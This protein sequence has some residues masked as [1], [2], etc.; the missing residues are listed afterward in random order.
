M[1]NPM[2]RSLERLAVED[3]DRRLKEWCQNDPMS[4]VRINNVY[5]WPWH[6]CRMVDTKKGDKPTM[7]IRKRQ[8]N[9]RSKM[10]FLR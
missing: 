10:F 7:W 2:A 4:E 3:L 8:A 1:F 5:A 6:C 9:I